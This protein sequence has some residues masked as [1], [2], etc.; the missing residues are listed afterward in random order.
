MGRGKSLR[1]V[2]TDVE[3]KKEALKDISCVLRKQ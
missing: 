2:K 1:R 3:D